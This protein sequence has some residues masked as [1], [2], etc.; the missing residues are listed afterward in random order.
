M[1]AALEYIRR[2]REVTGRHLTVTHLMAKVVGVVLSEVPE[3]NAVLRW[4]GIYLR[5]EI[6]VF[7]QVAIEN[8]RTGNI[9]LSGVKIEAPHRRS[10][11][12]IIDEFETKAARVRARQ[13]REIERSRRMLHRVPRLLVG[14][15][16]R[17]LGFLSYTLNL[18]LRWAGV[19]KDPFGSA[20][21]T[22]IGSLGLEAA[23]AP[24][25]PFS[26][27]PVLVAMGEVEDTPVADGEVTRVA[28]VMRLFATLD[29]RVVDG[30]HA[31]KMV[32]IVR[33]WFEHPF[34]HFEVPREGVHADVQD[35]ATAQGAGES[36]RRDVG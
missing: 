5:K 28:K 17:V 23:Y 12:E 21:V 31:A 36:T 8:P 26:R 16:L 32:R 33:D 24:L 30:A 2:F 18:D 34:D 13:D 27:V 1:D 7:F 3:I 9:D 14:L 22:N 15:A 11:I 19:P 6:A 20:M 35:S 4:R 29:H 10:L 25:V